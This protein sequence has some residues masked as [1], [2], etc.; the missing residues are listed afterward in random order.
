M[1]SH[2]SSLPA[3]SVMDSLRRLVHGLRVF[4]REAE[5]TAGLSGAQLFVLSRLA[6]GGAASVNDLAE[7][8]CTHQSSVSVVAQ[9]LVD[10]GLATRKKAAAD[11]RRVMLR[12]TPD[13]RR[14][15]KRAPMAAQEKLIAAVGRLHVAEARG[16]AELL[17]KLVSAA[18][19]NGTEPKLFFEEKRG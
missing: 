12:I 3:R 6:A 13:G 8:T 9:K 1:G 10:H 4:D 19:L 5:R 15:L 18:G 16:L 11:G 2:K 7:R 17:E 14:V